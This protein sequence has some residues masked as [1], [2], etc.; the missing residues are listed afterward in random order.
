MESV[1]SF[2]SVRMGGIFVVIVS[3]MGTTFQRIANF[4][5]K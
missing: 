3:K 5:K 4:A 1:L 2:V